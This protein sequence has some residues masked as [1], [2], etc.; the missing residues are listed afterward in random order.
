M[1]ASTE[2]VLNGE[3]PELG[4]CSLERNVVGTEKLSKYP[5]GKVVMNWNVF[6]EPVSTGGYKPRD[7]QTLPSCHSGYRSGLHYCCPTACHH[8]S[9]N[10]IL[11]VSTIYVG[12]SPG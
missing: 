3:G 9:Q 7:Y 4:L 11:S 12:T 1:K 5:E 8:F 10:H 6:Q 2:N